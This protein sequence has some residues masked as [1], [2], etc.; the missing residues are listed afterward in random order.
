MFLRIYIL[1]LIFNPVLGGHLFPYFA[2]LIGIGALTTFTIY[3]MA[4]KE[5]SGKPV[6]AAGHQNPLE[7]RVA[8]VFG[9]LY[10]VFSLLTQYTIQYFGHNGLNVLSYIVGVTDIDPFLLNMFQGKYADITTAVIS[11]ATLQAMASNNILKTIYALILSDKA[12]KKYILAGFAII[13]IAN[14]LLVF[15]L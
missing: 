4:A 6:E 9:L 1:V 13:I 10:V 3:R 8:L 7:L 15:F 5:P 11:A 12:V 2:A 14:I